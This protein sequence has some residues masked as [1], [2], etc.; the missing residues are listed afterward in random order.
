MKI[1]HDER[2]DEKQ[3]SSENIFS[4][5]LLH[6]FKD[7]VRLPN[8]HEST[9]EYIKHQGAVAILPVLPNGDMI[10]V[11]QYRY[12]IDSVIYEVPAGKLEKG[13]DPLECAKRE[14]SEE[15]GYE[16]GEFTYLTSI[17]TT[18]GFTN[19]TI[20][21]YAATNL[22]RGSQHPDEDEFIDVKAFSLNKVKEMV[23]K[24]EIY[25]SKSLAILLLYLF[26]K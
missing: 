17:V 4:G 22:V 10:F 6:V 2:L 25:D 12:P 8:G 14:L 13:E 9:R 23:L 18:P 16:A 11:R 19:E 24:G 3:L 20:H 26:H 21:L 15:T 7:K 5:R 1:I